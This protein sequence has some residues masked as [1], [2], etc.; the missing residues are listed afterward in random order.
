MNTLPT[1]PT[2]NRLMVEVHDYSPYQYTLMTSDAEWGK[3]FYFWGQGYHHPTM[4]GPQPDL[5]RGRLHPG[6]IPEDED[7]VH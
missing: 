3:M 5:G 6:A 7:Q 4:T 2:P 1:D